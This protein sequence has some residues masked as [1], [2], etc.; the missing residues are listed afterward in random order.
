VNGIAKIEIGNNVKIIGP[1][2]SAYIPLGVK[3]RLST[4]TRNLF[5]FNS[6]SK[7]DLSLRR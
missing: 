2:E 5:Y 4:P 7:R 6:D 3:H 1:N